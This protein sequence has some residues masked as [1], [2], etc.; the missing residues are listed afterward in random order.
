MSGPTSNQMSRNQVSP[1]YIL[2]EKWTTK[3]YLIIAPNFVDHCEMNSLPRRRGK[4]EGTRIT[5]GGRNEVEEKPSKVKFALSRFLY[6]R[7]HNTLAS[8]IN[9]T[10]YSVSFTH[11]YYLLCSGLSYVSS[12]S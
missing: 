9:K 10:L 4:V 8:T 1:K 12:Y 2:G 7:Y 3:N 11:S 5:K 6:F